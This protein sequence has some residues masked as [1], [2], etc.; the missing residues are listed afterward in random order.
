MKKTLIAMG[1][2]TATIMS[3]GVM[4]ATW[5]NGAVNGSAFEISGIL[6]PA[7]VSTPWEV[8]I[9]DAKTDLDVT[10]SEG[11]TQGT[12]N[13]SSA[14]PVLGIRSV[15]GGFQGGQAG[16]V[17]NITYGTSGLTFGSGSVA[18]LKLDVK[19]ASS[20]KIGT[21][22]ASLQ[23]VAIASNGDVAVSLNANT[24]SSAYYGGVPRGKAN[25]LQGAAAMSAIQALFPEATQNWPTGVT[26]SENGG[27][28]GFVDST[29]TFNTA[30]ASGIPANTSINITLDS[31]LN[32][33]TKWTAQLP[34]T[35]SFQ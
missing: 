3:G 33:D 28:W 12:V 21:L 23:G 29:K 24:S 26:V 5:T 30:Y 20:V 34:V 7:S 14:I 15:S 13:V 9:G 22:S 19:D 32:S 27:E 6:S 2:A 25:A 11:D 1:V 35:V 31:A 4:A 18:S 8:A 16:I 17:P 10:M